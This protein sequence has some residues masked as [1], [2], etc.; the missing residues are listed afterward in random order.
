MSFSPSSDGGCPFLNFDDEKLKNCLHSQVKFDQLTVKSSIGAN[1]EENAKAACK[2]YFEELQNLRA[3]KIATAKE[4][5]EVVFEKYSTDLFS[6]LQFYNNII[7]T[8]TRQSD[9]NIL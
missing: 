5:E 4:N 8:S 9:R 1:T 7:Q 6:P 3:K 2:A